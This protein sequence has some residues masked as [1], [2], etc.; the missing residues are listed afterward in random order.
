MAMELLKLYAQREASIGFAFPEDTK[1]Q[2]E[3]EK[4]LNI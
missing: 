3:F 4:N 2:M 1:E